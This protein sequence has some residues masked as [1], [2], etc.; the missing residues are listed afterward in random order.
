MLVFANLKF[1]VKEIIKNKAYQ[2]SYPAQTKTIK[3]KNLDEQ[4]HNTR[5]KYSSRQKELMGDQLSRLWRAC[6]LGRLVMRFL[7]VGVFYD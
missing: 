2:H 1:H 5:V 7:G 3:Q 4:K 6:G